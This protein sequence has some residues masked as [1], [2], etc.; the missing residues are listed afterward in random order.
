M[1]AGV[2]DHVWELSDI[3]AILGRWEEREKRLPA[4]YEYTKR[5][6]VPH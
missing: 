6:T 2:T 3:I 1:V 4:V 5:R